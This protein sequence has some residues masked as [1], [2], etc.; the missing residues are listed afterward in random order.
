MEILTPSVEHGQKADGRAQML[1]VRC[2][3]QQRFGNRAKK[4]RVDDLGVLKRQSGNLLRQ[5]ED[6]VEIFLHRQQLSFA[7][8]QPLGAG[9]CLTL[10][11]ASI[12]ARVIRDGAMP[13]L[14]ALFHVAA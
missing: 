13:A 5:C 11:T 12:S 14:V 8:G 7:F 10:R 6:N 3:G 1:G 9:R 2:N 4:D